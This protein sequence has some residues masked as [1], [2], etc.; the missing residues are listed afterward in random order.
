MLHP[1]REFFGHEFF[2]ES[3]SNLCG[4]DTTRTNII[5]TRCHWTIPTCSM[6]GIFTYIYHKNQPN[7]GKCSIH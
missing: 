6:Y 1:E 3:I 5:C 2:G 7:A 4:D